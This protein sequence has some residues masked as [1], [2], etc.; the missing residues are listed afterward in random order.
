MAKMIVKHHDTLMDR[1]MTK[2]QAKRYGNRHMPRDLKAYG[3]KTIIFTADSDIHGWSGYRI[4]YGKDV[5]V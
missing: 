1:L 4:N 3:F 2:D 5:R